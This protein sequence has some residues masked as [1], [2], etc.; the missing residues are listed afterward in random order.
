MQQYS[1]SAKLWRLVHAFLIADR[2]LELHADVTL[3]Q[4]EATASKI[5]DTLKEQFGKFGG[6]Y[7]PLLAVR[8]LP[9]I[10][11]YTGRN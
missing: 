5:G 10:A 1:N 8:F 2:A 4:D 11:Y 9:D 6:A 3:T 7:S